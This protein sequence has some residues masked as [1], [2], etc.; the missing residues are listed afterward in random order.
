MI[1]IVTEYNNYLEKLP[2]LINKTYYKAEYF[3][4]ALGISQ[5]TYYRKLREN[6]FTPKEVTVLTKILFPKETYK[7]E[8]MESLQDAYKE[9]E[10]GKTVSSAEMREMMRNQIKN[11][12]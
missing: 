6:S 1:D 11:Y 5:A 4:R 10:E 7:Q 9:L 12:Q 8:L 3:V 2:E